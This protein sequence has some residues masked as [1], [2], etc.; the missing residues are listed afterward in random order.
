MGFMGSGKSSFGKKLAKYLQLNHIDLDHWIE[1]EENLT[2]EEIFA[3]KGENYFR[4]KEQE[5]LFKTA[6]KKAVISLGGGTACNDHNINF[7]NDNGLSLYLKK[8]IKVLVNRLLS[9]KKVRPLIQ[10]K[11]AVELQDFISN[12][13]TEREPYYLKADLLIDDLNP[14]AKDVAAI[15]SST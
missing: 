12:K 3:E 1:A 9:S 5:L 13:M 2:I 10:G 7:I 15:I 6:D 4:A 11:S 8:D 14:Q